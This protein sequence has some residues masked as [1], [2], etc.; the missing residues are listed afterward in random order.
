[1]SKPSYGKAGSPGPT[2]PSAHGVRSWHRTT[3]IGGALA[4]SAWRPLGPGGSV[5]DHERQAP[6]PVASRGPGR[7]RAGQFGAK[8][9]PQAGGEQCCRKLLPGCPAVPRGIMTEQGKSYGAAP[10]ASLPGVEQ[11]QSRALTTRCANAQ[12]PTRQ[13]ARRLPG[14]PSPGQAQRF[15]SAYGPIAPPFRP[16]RPL[17]SAS[18]ERQ[19]MRPRFERGAE[20]TGTKQA[21]EGEG[22]RGWETHAAAESLG[23]NNLTKPARARLMRGRSVRRTP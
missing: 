2:Q 9:A 23:L 3:P 12:R 5:F 4:P 8:L 19:E 17:G 20:M 14:C 18:T 1:M 13:R 22:G 15:L 10:R 16:R 11:R 21:A 6:C 7:Q